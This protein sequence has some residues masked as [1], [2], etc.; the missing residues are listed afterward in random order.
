MDTKLAA[1]IARSIFCGTAIAGV[2]VAGNAA[3]KDHDVTVAI[4]VSTEGLDLSQTADARTFYTRLKNAAWVACTRGD[5]AGLVPVD[6]V[7]GC[8]EKALGGAIHSANAPMLTQIY[9][10]THTIQQ[11]AVYGINVATQIAGVPPQ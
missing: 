4:H 2:Q 9:L 5:R 6:D 3:A 11:A 1:A 7:K 8:C 10:A